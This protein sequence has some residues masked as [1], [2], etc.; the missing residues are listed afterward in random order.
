MWQLI[1]WLILVGVGSIGGLLARTDTNGS[2]F[3]HADGAGNVTG[4]LAGQQNMA[5]RYMK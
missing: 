5:A 4:L 1:A 2:A 3:Y